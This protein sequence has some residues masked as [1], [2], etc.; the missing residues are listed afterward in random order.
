MIFCHLPHFDT[1]YLFPFKNIFFLFLIPYFILFK[2]NFLLHFV[3]KTTTLSTA[4]K[5]NILTGEMKC[6]N[7]RLKEN[8]STIIPRSFAQSLFARNKLHIG[9]NARV[10]H[11]ISFSLICVYAPNK[12]L[13]IRVE[14]KKSSCSFLSVEVN[15]VNYFTL[16]C[17]M[18]KCMQRVILWS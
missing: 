10:K 8:V 17:V 4:H 3:I 9:N 11:K 7:G 12:L 14:K 15:Y 16:L 18:M 5:L 13:F 2:N 1:F 6:A